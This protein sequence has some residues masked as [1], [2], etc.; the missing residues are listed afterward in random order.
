VA[1]AAADIDAFVELAMEFSPA[2]IAKLARIK[3]ALGHDESALALYSKA[4][5][6]DAEL[7]DALAGI[8]ELLVA[9][10]DWE[11]AC[12][13]KQK[14]AHSV[15]VSEE[16]YGLLIEVGEMWAHRAK[17]VPMAALAYEEALAIKPRDSWLLHTLIW[18]YGELQC[19]EKLIETLRVVVEIHE[20]PTAKAKSLFA[21]AMVV[22][23]H[24]G[25][26]RRAAALLEETL[27]LDPARLDAFERIVRVH[28]ELR[29]WM[30]LKHAY[31]R[32]LRR[33]RTDSD[34]DLKHA[35]F[36]QLGII[37]RDRLGDAA[38]ALDSFRA[39]QRVKPD[40]VDVR[41]GM[42]ELFVVTDQLD[43]GVGMLRGMLRKH[44]Q[45]VALY[46]ELYELLLRKRSFDRAWCAVDALV[47]LGT[48]LDG[49]KA[50]FY[51][52]YPPP[53]LSKVPGT[54][55]AGAWRSHILHKELDPALTAIFA[56]VAPAVLRAR[57]AL[58][59]F[60][61]LRQS[62]GEPLRPT[63]VLQHEVMSAVSNAS[64]ILSFVTPSLHVRN[65]TAPLSLAPAKSS[66]FVSLEA[67]EALPTDALA[68]VV[69]KKLAEM[70]PELVARTLC[71]SVSELKALV[72]LAVQLS[73][74]HIAVP[75]TGSAAFDR[76]I[77]NAVTREERAGLR[78]A[79]SAAKAQGSELDVARWSQLAEISAARVGLLLSGRIDASKRGMHGDPRLPG[80]L[81]PK[82]KLS[83]LLLFSVSEEY[84]ELRGAIGVGV[85]SNAAA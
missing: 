80:D 36:F 67:C 33:L 65:G 15:S 6:L 12:A 28:T 7:R 41:K 74:P 54:L 19:W 79:I 34:E 66:L 45:D 51:N 1:K 32:M 44:P 18:V 25:D 17:N 4:L 58:V 59:P 84:A 57:L 14:L 24:L 77:A 39:A 76:A 64:E 43:E 13:F 50:R 22:R 85:E 38:R 29:D 21:M 27:D 40:A 16:Q 75:S 52:D 56:L 49:E 78:A 81:S 2:H 8:A 73:E 72:A 30:E 23:D 3:R 20:D 10:E 42:V 55:T 31:G 9:R 53:A 11:R 60:Q 47:A 63:G 48:Q 61:A 70:R 5:T 37:Y 46:A 82:E 62:L 71:P 26:L 83:E 68:F 35:L 69:G